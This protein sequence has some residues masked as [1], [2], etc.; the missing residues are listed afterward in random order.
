MTDTTTIILTGAAFGT[1]IYAA[2][3]IVRYLH[4]ISKWQ[5]ARNEEVK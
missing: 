1:A 2:W 3:S 5:Q 4:H